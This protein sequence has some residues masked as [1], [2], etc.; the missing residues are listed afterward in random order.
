MGQALC[1]KVS[2]GNKELLNLQNKNVYA[3]DTARFNKSV[4]TQLLNKNVWFKYITVIHSDTASEGDKE[5]VH[6]EYGIVEYISIN[7]MKCC[8]K[9][10]NNKYHEIPLSYIIQNKSLI[11]KDRN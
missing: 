11:L 3:K 2:G 8:V 6:V 5:E 9:G 4:K 7:T 10:N 1:E